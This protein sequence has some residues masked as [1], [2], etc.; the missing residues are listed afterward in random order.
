PETDSVAQRG[1]DSTDEPDRDP[2]ARAMTAQAQ[3]EAHWRELYVQREKQAPP[4]VRATLDNY[5]ERA[6]REGW[7]FSVSYTDVMNKPVAE[8]TG[9]IPPTKEEVAKIAAELEAKGGGAALKGGTVNLALPARY[10]SR[11]FGLVTPVRNQ[12]P[13]CGSCWAFGSVAAFETN[14]LKLHGGNPSAL[15]LSD[16]QVLSCTGWLSTCGGG[17]HHIAL[18]YICDNA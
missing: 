1:A 6:S 9:F 5:R 16:Q 13:T 4:D 18:G 7:T 11:D 3:D 8:V 2:A 10:D 14:F 15:D 12:G 17:R